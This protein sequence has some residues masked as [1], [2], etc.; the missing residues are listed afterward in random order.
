MLTHIQLQHFAIVDQLELTFHPGFCVLTGETGAGKSI[1]V[2]AISMALGQRADTSVIRNPHDRCDISLCFDITQNTAAQAWLHAQDLEADCCIIRRVIARQGPAKSTINGVAFPLQQVKALAD[3]LIHIHS[4]HQQQALLQPDQQR[5]ALDRFAGTTVLVNSV[6]KLYQQ[7]KHLHDAMQTLTQQQDNT[8]EIAFLKYQLEELAQLN[9]QPNEWEQLTQEHQQLQNANTLMS[10][11]NQAIT[12]TVEHDEYSAE[13]LVQQA[14]HELNTIALDNPELQAIQELL[15]TAAIHL[16]EAGSELQTYRNHLDLSP[17]HLQTVEARLSTIF[18]IA[19][20]HHCEPAALLDIQQS[21]QAKLEDALSHDDKLAA[22]QHH[23]KTLLEKYNTLAKRL[24]TKRQKAAETLSAA[25]TTAIRDLDITEGIIEITL[26]TVDA[27]ITPTGQERVEFQVKTNAGSD[28]Q[29]LQKVASGGELSRICLAL[30]VMTAT[31]DHTPTLIFDEV[32]VG[33]SGKTAAEVGKQLRQ[34]GD[35]TQV[36]CITHLPQVA[37]NGHHHYKV[38]KSSDS[39]TTQ[40]NIEELS[41]TERQQE[42]ARL[43]SG[44]KITERTLA[45]ANELLQL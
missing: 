45:H 43:L 25:L 26:P 14:L 6:K 13:R 23:E 16:K 33:I 44:T 22:F 4:Q 18:D 40:S 42:I 27:P 17:E 32:D 15:N 37:A 29:P 2:D 31:Q 24:T 8:Q 7:W 38:S 20:K 12:L 10:Q 28:F 5:A 3:L 34:L 9:L 1:W 21:L 19:R 35:T 36:L 30:Q 11:L 41:D 39:K